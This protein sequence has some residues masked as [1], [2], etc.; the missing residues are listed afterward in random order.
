M[1]ADNLAQIHLWEDW[2]EIMEGVPVGVIARPG[3]RIGARTSPAARAYRY[4]KVPA[5]LAYGLGRMPAPA[6]AF[7]NVPLHPASSTEI[8]A[9]GGWLS[10]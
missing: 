4:A 9:G 8:R 5:A 7:A 1:G 3:D 6:W 2:R 10:A